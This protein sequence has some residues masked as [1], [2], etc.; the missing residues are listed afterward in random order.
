MIYKKRGQ[1]SLEFALLL[2]GVIVVAVI[3]AYQFVKNTPNLSGDVNDIKKSSYGLFTK[4]ANIS[5]K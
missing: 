2:F 3:I 4:E 1:L 5:N